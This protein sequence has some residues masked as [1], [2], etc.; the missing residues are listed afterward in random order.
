LQRG[1][2]AVK[3]EEEEEEEEMEEVKWKTPAQWH[4]HHR[5][6]ASHYLVLV[7]PLRDRQRQRQCTHYEGEVT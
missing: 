4:R 6:Q 2:D 5:N 7:Q 1:G 3:E